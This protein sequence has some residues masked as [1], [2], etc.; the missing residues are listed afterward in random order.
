[1]TAISCLEYIDAILYINLDHRL[2]RKEHILQEI[3]KID[4]TLSKTHQIH[5][6]YVPAHG[7]LG[8]TK[9]H[10]KALQLFMKHHEWK[11]CLILEDDFTFVSSSPE[12]VNQHIVDLFQ[13]C[14]T[15]DILMLAHGIYL[16]SAEPTSSPQVQRILCGQTTSGYILNRDYLPTLLHNFQESYENLEKNGKSSWG[17][18]DMHWKRLQPQ[19]KWF[20][21]HTRIGYQYESYSDVENYVTNYKC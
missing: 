3:R 21:Y 11:N 14:P 18:L 12:E 4:P 8:C 9:S 6:E 5:A 16:F 10:I 13:E 15:Y 17:C 19:G 1:M 20:A 7:A 2:D